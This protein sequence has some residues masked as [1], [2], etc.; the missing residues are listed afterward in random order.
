MIVF[1]M[2]HTFVLII[3]K[4][5]GCGKLFLA[6]LTK[7]AP[8]RKLL[9]ANKAASA[10]QQPAETAWSRA[11][12]QHYVC[13]DIRRAGSRVIRHKALQIVVSTEDRTNN[14]LRRF[15][16]QVTKTLI[17]LAV[18]AGFASASFAQGATPATPAT[19]AVKATP[20]APAAA[21]KKMEA[22]KAAEPAK[23]EAA[24]TEAPKADAGKPVAKHAKAKGHKAKTEVKPEA[25]PAVAPAPTAK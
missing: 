3:E 12:T 2:I 7:P 13:T 24:K 20:A 25:K 21:E 14:P 23:L 8:E 19:P 1:P 22:P 5:T 17:A 18:A 16:M 6:R 11:D 4:R 10:S 15:K 9:Q